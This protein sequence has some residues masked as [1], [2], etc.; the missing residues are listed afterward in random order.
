MTELLLI[1]AIG[2]LALA[3]ATT[4][5]RWLLQR[6]VGDP[7]LARTAELVG[8]GVSR[9]FKR[10][11]A[12]TLAVVGVVGAALFLVYG[13][14][15]QTEAVDAVAPREFGLWVA[16]SLT[17]GAAF[18][19]VA[20]WVSAW[21]GREAS[22][23]VAAGVRR[24]LDDSL[25]I[26]I[27]AGAVSGVVALALALL[28]LA[29]LFLVLYLY[30]GS[31]GGDTAQALAEA[32]R[33]PSLMVGFVLGAALVALLS[34]LGGGLFGKVADLGADLVGTLEASSPQDLASNPAAVA[35]L[36]G[37]HVGDG[38]PRA[39]GVFAAAVTE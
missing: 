27:R 26:A 29:G 39:A 8:G 38:A 2:V 14:A 24:S 28:G 17:L 25:Q 34:Q 32:P 1:C 37:D 11:C 21:A 10:Q 12:V 16:I 4:V 20:A 6:P 23:R 22:V 3:F 19:V 31:F 15:Y 30:V 18:A 5:A 13:V 35:D 36:V 7:D 9:Y 33:L